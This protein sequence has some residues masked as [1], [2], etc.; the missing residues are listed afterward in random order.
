MIGEFRTP[1]QRAA[2]A[3]EWRRYHHAELT[4]RGLVVLDARGRRVGAVVEAEP[5][6]GG[7]E[8]RVLHSAS[9]ENVGDGYKGPVLGRTRRGST[10]PY[11]CVEFVGFIRGGSIV[12]ATHHVCGAQGFGLRYDDSCPACRA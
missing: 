9:S 5:V 7:V 12:K 8:V 4:A 6:F 2:R 1:A 3:L 11:E 10:T